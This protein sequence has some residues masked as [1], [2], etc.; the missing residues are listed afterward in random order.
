MLLFCAMYMLISAVM[1]WF[2]KPGAFDDGWSRDTEVLASVSKTV[3]S[4]MGLGGAGWLILLF[5]EKRR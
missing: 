2:I 5:L 4:F 1:F 3:W